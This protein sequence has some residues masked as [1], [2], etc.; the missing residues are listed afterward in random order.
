MFKIPLFNLNYDEREQKAVAD[1]IASKWISSGP[2]CIELEKI[3]RKELDIEYAYGVANCTA[4]LHLAMCSLGIGA[5]DEVIV[6]SL[7]FVATVNAVCYVGAR[8][9]F[10]DIVGIDDLTISPMQIK[11]LI[12]DRTKAIVVMH[13]AG[14]PCHMEE[15]VDIAREHHL[16][17]IEDAC[18]GP[19]SE[20]QGKKLGTIG[21]VG[22]FSFFSNKNISTGEGGMIVTRHKAVGDRIRLLRSHGMTTMSYER[23][24]GHS[25]EYDV[26]ILGYNYRMDDIHAA[27]GIVQ[28][29]KLH[30]DL[31]KRSEVRALYLKNLQD[32]EKIC[33]PFADY[34][35]FCSNY[36]MPTVLVN[37]DK[38]KR[39]NVRRKFQ[40]KGI[41]TS[42]H[43]PAAHRFSIYKDAFKGDMKQTEYVTDCEITLPMYACLSE[44][45]ICYI[46][47]S[48][49]QILSEG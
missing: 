16:F 43:Y 29:Q 1:T 48:Y 47:D 20:Y 17:V 41:Q 11:H 6:P 36:I 26:S 38:E 23:A 33:L 15:I 31:E 4:A 9:V 44:K 3:F 49:K 42:I 39:D 40:E 25:T 32:T 46:C 14:F 37:A 7:T 12:T 19:L 24:K 30:E 35:R 18:H 2:R 34:T 13:Y 5:G 28:M 27:L 21:D 22:C 8:P 45:E 10:C